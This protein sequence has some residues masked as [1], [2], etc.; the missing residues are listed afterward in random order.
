VTSLR[1]HRL[2]GNASH[3]P[4]EV[5]SLVFPIR[6]HMRLL[7]LVLH[8]SQQILQ[9]HS[10]SEGISSISISTEQPS[11]KL[12]DLTLT[13]LIIAPL[14]QIALVELLQIPQRHILIVRVYEGAVEVDELYEHVE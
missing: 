3:H 2:L 4:V 5:P 14:L 8:H 11:Q 1:L 7:L 9:I 10:F 13:P 6:R 12:L